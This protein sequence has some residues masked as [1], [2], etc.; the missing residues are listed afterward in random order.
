[1]P[2][3]WKKHEV[4]FC[5]NLFVLKHCFMLDKTSNERLVYCEIRLKLL[6]AIWS[7][8]DSEHRL[9][10]TSLAPTDLRHHGIVA[11]V[12]LVPGH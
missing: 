2:T 11:V 5:V 6:K 1:M 8:L 9:I 12:C 4:V 3:F 10:L 7:S